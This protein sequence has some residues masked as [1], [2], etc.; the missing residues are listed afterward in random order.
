M[1]IDFAN[2]WG[3]LGLFL[4]S[5]LA[6]TVVPLSPEALVLLLESQGYDAP[7]LIA[8]A[9]LG[10]Y[11][12]SLTYYYMAIGGRNLALHRFVSIS[13]GKLA[14]AEA[15]FEKWGSIILFFSWVPIVGEPLIIV[16]G[17]LNVRLSVF[18]V[19]VIIGRI[20]RF[21]I[22]LYTIGPIID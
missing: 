7:L 22:L 1:H 2:E 16:S 17:L 10:G 6:A 20:V 15:R 8:T 3:Y 9:T 11:L 19:W 4:V 13:S 21:A 18:T 12:G 5:F 14:K